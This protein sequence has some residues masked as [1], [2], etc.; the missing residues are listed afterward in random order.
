MLARSSAT[1][2]SSQI[3]RKNASSESPVAR[4][5]ARLVA[6]TSPRLSEMRTKR[7]VEIE[8]RAE[9]LRVPDFS[10]TEE[11]H[12]SRRDKNCLQDPDDLWAPP[13]WAA[14]VLQPAAIEEARE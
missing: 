2:A 4:S 13:G 1:A 10:M 8:Y 12:R 7:R 3:G 14:E 11:C 9:Q 6:R 5:T